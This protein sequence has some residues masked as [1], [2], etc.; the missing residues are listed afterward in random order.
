[1]PRLPRVVRYGF[2]F[3]W[4]GLATLARMALDPALGDS[5]PY[6]TYFVCIAIVAWHVGSGPA[7]LAAVL[8]YGVATFFFIPPRHALAFATVQHAV[9]SVAY[10][11]AAL[12][13]VGLR[14]LG[15]RA[16][17]SALARADALRASEER[18]RALVA[19][20]AQVVA[21]AGPDGG[22][23]EDSPSWRAFTGQTLDEMRAGGWIEAIHPEDRE[24]VAESWRRA[25]AEGTPVENQYRL[26]RADGSYAW[27]LARGAPVL[28]EDGSV[29]EWMGTHQD[30][31]DRYRAEEA[32]SRLAAIVASSDDAIVA[33][34][35]DGVVTDW[36]EGAERLFGYTADEMIGQPIARLVP[37]GSKD[38]IP[39]ILNAIRRGERVDHYE[40][41]R[42]RKDGSHIHV[43]LTISPVRDASGKIVGASK[44]ARDITDRRQAEERLRRH[45]ERTRQLLDYSRAIMTSM[46]E[47][48]YLVDAD[49]LVTFVNPA[50]ERLFGWTREELLGRRMHDVTHYAHPDGS[51][52]PAEEC[53]G[54]RVLR[55][56]AVLTDH[57]DV[58]IRKDGSFFPVTYSASPLR[59]GGRIVGLVVVFR[60]VTQAM[61]ALAE[62][63]ELLAVTEHARAQAEAANRAKEEFLSVV[64]HE[65]R[66][67]LS[68]ILN[69]LR[70]LRTGDP[71]HRQRALESMQRSAEAQ[72]KLVEDLLDF[73]RITSG[74]LRVETRPIALGDVARASLD[75]VLPGAEAKG[76]RVEADLAAP[77]AVVAADPERLQQVAWN[78]LS[79]AVKFTPPGGVVRVA[80]ERGDGNV[81]LV[82]KDTGEGIAAEFLPYVFEPFHQAA[83][84][85]TRRQGGLGLGLAIVRHLVE[86]HGGWV[87]VASEG[88]GRGTTFTVTLPAAAP[89]EPPQPQRQ[90][91]SAR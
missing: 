61:R 39:G 58:F 2:A 32:Q 17:R 57:Q 85:A 7:L 8:A 55:D 43:S 37:S 19:A 3:A 14:F 47:G 31:S 63:E 9:G 68:S 50:A 90:A 25:L 27:T 80:V 10:F 64:S 81:R 15:E 77:G 4:V 13:I 35:L 46:A 84:A 26:R 73:S 21:S 34:N 42:V 41:E 56:G 52:F 11:A 23:V 74:R 45:A 40:T 48:L 88:P 86:A 30:I 91:R 24:R 20:S 36:N 69:W 18:F 67:P 79:N 1:M 60:D 53:A 65:L 75:T 66:T 38:E 12:G 78:L 70:V 72:T 51:P 33:K 83:P 71:K 6:V 89:A 87:A 49:G 5:L 82:V 44:I 54:L 62:R 22:V 59:E 29:R 28:N 16:E 76:L